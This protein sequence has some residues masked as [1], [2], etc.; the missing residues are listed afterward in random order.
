M[1]LLETARRLQPDVMALDV[2]LPNVRSLEAVANL[3]V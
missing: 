3:R 1:P 2:N